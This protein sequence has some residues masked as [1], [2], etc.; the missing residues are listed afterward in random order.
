MEYASFVKRREEREG[1]EGGGKTKI[2]VPSLIQCH[3]SHDSVM[4]TVKSRKRSAVGK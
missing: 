2:K 1:R 4:L 3:S